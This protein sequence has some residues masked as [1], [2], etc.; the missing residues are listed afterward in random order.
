MGMKILH[1]NMNHTKEC[2][3]VPRSSQFLEKSVTDPD[4]QLKGVGEPG[5]SSRP[6]NKEG[7][8]ASK[9]FFFG[10]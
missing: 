3:S 4:L 9:K 8:V 2:I 7:G 1:L 5:R 10:P 6:L